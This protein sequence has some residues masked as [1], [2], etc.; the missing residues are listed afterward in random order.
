[1]TDR[2]NPAIVPH[3]IQVNVVNPVLVQKFAQSGVASFIIDTMQYEGD[4][5]VVRFQDPA[6]L[7]VSFPRN[8]IR[9]QTMRLDNG[10]FLKDPH[11]SK[12][13]SYKS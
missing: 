8:D 5:L 10:T 7:V 4:R 6:P 3:D 9:L 11:K 1:M 2:E 12:S 13:R